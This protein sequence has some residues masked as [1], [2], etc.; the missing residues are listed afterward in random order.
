MNLLIIG[1]GVWAS[2][3][4]SVLSNS[5]FGVNLTSISA[6]K[7]LSDP[8]Q[9]FEALENIE[10]I[11]ICTKPDWQLELLPKLSQFGGKIILEKP[12][13]WD[14]NSMDRLSE[15]TKIFKGG[16]QLSEPWTYSNIWI[17]ARREIKETSNVEF[18]V[19]R[20]GPTGHNFMS[21]VLDWI[22][23]DINLLFDLYGTELLKSEISD[24]HWSKN[25]SELEFKISIGTNSNFFVSVGNFNGKKVASWESKALTVN[26]LTSTLK[27]G[28]SEEQ[29]IQ[30]INP[31]MLQINSTVQNSLGRTRDQLEVQNYFFCKLSK[32][33]I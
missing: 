21:P 7:A 27:K 17:S 33:I 11:W 9:I 13:I 8:S 24:I 19:E 20:G 1:Q 15:F 14:E 10:V 3:I 25:Q 16:L 30:E 6:R 4:Q 31:F 2:K 12:Y 28:L 18:I 23:H 5:T 22:P 29:I 32:D 26:F